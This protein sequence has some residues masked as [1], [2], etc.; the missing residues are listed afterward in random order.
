MRFQNAPILKLFSKVSVFIN[1]FGCFRVDD[2]Q[3][4]MKKFCVFKRKRRSLV[5]ALKKDASA[6]TVV[7]FFYSLKKQKLAVLQ[8]VFFFR[9]I[10]IVTRIAESIHDHCPQLALS[11]RAGTSVGLN[12]S[13]R[14]AITFILTSSRAKTQS[15]QNYRFVVRRLAYCVL[16]V[17]SWLVSNAFKF[18]ISFPSCQKFL[19]IKEELG[20]S[21]SL[22]YRFIMNSA[23]ILLIWTALGVFAIPTAISATGLK[24]GAHLITLRHSE[25]FHAL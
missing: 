22:S 12:C 6:K 2:R 24:A 21:T 14:Y 8:G 4:R 20:W 3:K 25:L 16:F 17:S 23:I 9:F 5:G 19:L 13:C 7:E 10:M 18:L 15:F 1:V 11:K